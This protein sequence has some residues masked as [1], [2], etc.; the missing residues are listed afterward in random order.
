MLTKDEI[1]S[2]VQACGIGTSRRRRKVK[3]PVVLVDG[4][5]PP[6]LGHDNG[7]TVCTVGKGW[8]IQNT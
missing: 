7:C 1:R 2:V 6:I 8:V 5:Q 3:C 4:F